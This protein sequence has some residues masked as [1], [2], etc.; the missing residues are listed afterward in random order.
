MSNNNI[1][2]T[3]EITREI[4]RNKG[5]EL[6][7]E[8][9]KDNKTKLTLKDNEGYLYYA[10]LVY[11]TVKIR[12]PRRFDKNNIY[13]LYNIKLWLSKNIPYFEL[14]SDKY[15]DSNT[16]LVFKDQE[17]YLYTALLGNLLNNHIP[18]K[19]DIDNQYTLDNI[20]LFLKLKLNDFNLADETYKRKKHKITLYD[21]DGFYYQS[22]L[23]DLENGCFPQMFHTSNKFTINNIKLWLKINNKNFILLSEKYI[24]NKQKLLWKCTKEN[25]GEIFD[26]DLSDILHSNCG[27]PFCAGVRTGISN[28]LA[29][30]NPELAKQW[31][32]EKNKGIT[33]YDVTCGS[34]QE[35]Y[36]WKCDKC[37]HEW[38]SN[39][40]NRSN[41]TNC[42]KCNESKGEKQL[43]LILAKYNV[44]HDYQYTFNDLI[45]VN[46]G[47]LRFDVP[48]FWDKEKIK[49]RMLIEYDGEQH[50]K[51]IEGMMT[52]E[53]FEILQ[54]H[55]ELKNQYCKSNNIKLIRIPYW[56]FNDIEEIIMKEFKIN[57]YYV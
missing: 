49:L 46:G 22:F 57:S 52:K 31:H 10:P 42:P 51:W 29:T 48:V 1:T 41:G 23:K 27:C 26:M 32:P 21:K 13:T 8:E 30:K 18:Y 7:S 28:C 39:V 50:F 56:D 53:Q 47:L 3:L 34:S 4:V 12:N 55:D 40:L 14:V 15:I 33:P 45:G 37:G 6:L 11:F 38:K 17:G 20:R 5:L 9:Y 24:D 2:Y 35:K 25:C 19:F 16:N 44:P 43:D 36:W 54:I